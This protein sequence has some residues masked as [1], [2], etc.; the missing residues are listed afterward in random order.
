MTKSVLKRM[1]DVIEHP[2]NKNGGKKK[3]FKSDWILC[4]CTFCDNIFMVKTTMSLTC[5]HG[6]GNAQIEMVWGKPEVVFVCE[7]DPIK[8]KNVYER[9]MEKVK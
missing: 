2:D 5:P 8:L 7:H 4:S 6:C 3:Y 9:A 1:P